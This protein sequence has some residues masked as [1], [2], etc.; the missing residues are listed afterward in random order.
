MEENISK[1][2]V[3]GIKIRT[4]NLCMILISFILYILLI[5]ATVSA[6]YRYKQ[7][8]SAMED[9][10]ACEKNADMIEEGSDYLTEQVRLYT[11]TMDKKYVDEYFKEVYTVKRRDSALEEMKALHL[12]EK[13]TEYLQSALDNSNELMEEEIYAM[14]LI[15]LAQES[16]M[17]LFPDLVRNMKI[18]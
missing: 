3:R 7:M 4:I 18:K 6:S 12:G 10:I 11:V 13:G 14:K 16:D 15:S 2:N 17:S 1:N 5:L 8:T 9:Y